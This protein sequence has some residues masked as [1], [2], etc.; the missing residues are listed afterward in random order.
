MTKNISPSHIRGDDGSIVIVTSPHFF[1]FFFLSWEMTNLHAPS[2]S[3]VIEILLEYPTTRPVSVSVSAS[4]I[5]QV[6]RK[7]YSPN[8][9]SRLLGGLRGG[10]VVMMPPLLK[11]YRVARDMVWMVVFYPPP[12]LDCP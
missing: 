3:S 8:I 6:A 4:K 1:F 12:G 2:T 10:A 9:L 7:Q 11:E 5:S